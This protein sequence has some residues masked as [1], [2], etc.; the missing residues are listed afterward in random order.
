MTSAVQ[1]W[2]EC[3]EDIPHSLHAQLK[4]DYFYGAGVVLDLL[5]TNPESPGLLTTIEHITNELSESINENRSNPGG[6]IHQRW[7]KWKAA[8]P[9]CPI[10]VDAAED[11]ATAQHDEN[12]RMVFFTG[13][14]F[15]LTAMN[16]LVGDPWRVLTPEER[17]VQ[18]QRLE[19]MANEVHSF[20]TFTHIQPPNLP[21]FP[22]N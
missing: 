4:L 7:L 13:A 8:R 1:F 11:D 9:H 12:H 19:T 2:R 14:G 20:L 6:I 21:S 22:R 5:T 16:E 10:C 15:I 17:N 18:N 3:S